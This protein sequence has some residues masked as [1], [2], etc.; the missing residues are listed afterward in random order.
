M[1][2]QVFITLGG[3]SLSEFLIFYYPIHLTPLSL[4]ENHFGNMNDFVD[5]QNTTLECQVSLSFAH[6]TRGKQT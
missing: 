2:C 6:S 4:F 5:K 3:E 1:F